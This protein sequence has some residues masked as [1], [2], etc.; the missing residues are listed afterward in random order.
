MTVTQA[1]DQ[2]RATPSF[3]SSVSIETSELIQLIEKANLAPSSMNLQPWEFL[4][5]HSPADKMRL[6]GVS[7]GQKKIAEASA[8]L[9]LLGNLELALN[10]VKIGQGNA[11]LGI[12][13]QARAKSFAES[14]ARAY[15]GKPEAARDEAFRCGGIWAMNFMLL[16]KEAGWDTAPMG[17][18]EPAKLAEEFGLPVTRIPI[19]LIGIGKAN[20]EVV[21]YQ[22]AFRLPVQDLIHEG[23]Y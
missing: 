5:C 22:R 19:L 12:F 21:I 16:S 23:T 6:Q 18:F 10:A 20:P 14:A 8:V 9:V 13:D 4:I 11:E 2:R 1:V 17:G 3:D 15:N 7:Y